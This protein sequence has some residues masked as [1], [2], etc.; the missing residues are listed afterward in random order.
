MIER[1]GCFKEFDHDTY[2]FGTRCTVRGK[3]STYKDHIP[4]DDEGDCYRVSL[5]DGTLVV[6]MWVA[7]KKDFVFVM[8]SS[9]FKIEQFL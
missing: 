2:E 6:E 8:A 4:K 9:S 7:M 1:I 3:M 5:I